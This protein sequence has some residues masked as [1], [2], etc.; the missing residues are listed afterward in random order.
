MGKHEIPI[1]RFVSELLI[2]RSNRDKS[3]LGLCDEE[4]PSV[5]NMIRKEQPHFDCPAEI[6]GRNQE[7]RRLGKEFLPSLPCYAFSGCWP[8]LRVKHE[9]A[10]MVVLYDDELT[11]PA[12]GGLQPEGSVTDRA[13]ILV[14]DRKGIWPRIGPG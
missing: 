8:D 5:C 3:Y 2:I 7:K 13:F 9:R 14:S 6:R 4:D 11:G 1:R 10:A 12:Y